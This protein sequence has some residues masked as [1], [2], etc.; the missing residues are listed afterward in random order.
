MIEDMAKNPESENPE[1]DKRRDEVLERMLHTP[2][3]PHKD[4]PKGKAKPKKKTPDE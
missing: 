3:K 2:P 1:H 4:K